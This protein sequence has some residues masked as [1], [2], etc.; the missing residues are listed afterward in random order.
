MK[1]KADDESRHDGCLNWAA[2]RENYEGVGIQ[3]F[4]IIEADSIL[5]NLYYAGEK[6]PHMYWEKFEKHVTQP[7]DHNLC[8]G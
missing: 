4:N 3:A 6:A 2:L 1:I 5:A 7:C 8:Q